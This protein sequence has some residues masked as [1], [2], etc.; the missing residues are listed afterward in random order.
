MT[1]DVPSPQQAAL[2]ERARSVLIKD[3]RVRGV[4]LSGSFGGGT[5]DEFSDIDLWVV[6]DPDDLDGVCADGPALCDA[7]ATVVL[8]NQIGSRVF[9]CVTSDWMR[10]DLT[11]GTTEEVAGRTTSTVKPL[12]DPDNLSALLGARKPPL[13][14]DPDRI[15]ALTKDLYRVLGLLPVVIG[16]EEYLVGVSGVELLRSAVIQLMLQDVA[17]ENRGG[18]LHLNRLLPEERQRALAELPAVEATRESVI[19]G[20]LACARLFIPLAR[21]LHDRLDLAWPQEL[22]DA[23]R[24]HL[25]ATLDIQIP[26]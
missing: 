23:A 18:A 4:W 25:A 1:E 12:Y 3:A 6:V 14:P 19:A 7:I 24:R 21:E 17:V 22:E 2:I 13:Q 11:F 15:R 5:A 8:R 10:L 26:A 16:R 9:S 20:H